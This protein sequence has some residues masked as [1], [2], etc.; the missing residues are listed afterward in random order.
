MIQSEQTERQLT[1]LVVDD[2]PGV[3]RSVE[4]IL[5]RKDYHVAK[6]LCVA[7]AL[8][9][10]EAGTDFDLVI[11][12]LMMPQVGGME[13]LKIVKDRWPATPVLMITGYAS[14]ASAVEATKLGAA[15]YLPKPFTPDELDQAVGRI[16]NESHSEVLQG[17]SGQPAA[18]IDVDMPFDQREVA[19]AT[20]PR[21]VEHLTRSDLTVVENIPGAAV[22]YCSKG[23][24]SC[25]RMDRQ[26]MCK[27]PECPLV[28]A[29]RK[30]A[31]KAGVVVSFVPDPIDVDMPF[32]RTEVASST[33][34]AYAD[35]LGRSD[36]PI[37][38][39]WQTGKQAAGAPKVLVVD[40]E[41]V[42]ANGIRRTLARKPYRVAEAFSGQ[43]ALSRVVAE[44]FDMVLLDMRL[45]DADG[46]ELIS[47]LK[48]RRPGLKVV[49]VT[50]YASVDTAVEAIKRGA[51]DYIAKP[52]T[53]D[54]LYSVANRVLGRA[55]A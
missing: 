1:V 40:D 29:E 35:A 52:F 27:Q 36:M 8:D 7:S 13:L 6:A 41:P 2:E 10:L 49:I 24:R 16:L 28:V 46:L 30:K 20:S 44:H 51:N 12:D 3:C 23:E 31:A 38:G 45:P 33:S 32:S 54:E 47:A 25:K 48:K 19:L 39:F 17:R 26:G 18:P 37:T 55:V 53:P 43:E 4:K 50:G 9:T 34:Q 14:I 5:S 15:A 42:V 22:R 11:A 21:Y